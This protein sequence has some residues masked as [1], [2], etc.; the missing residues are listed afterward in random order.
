M[1]SAGTVANSNTAANATSTA[2]GG[3][4]TS[5]S[6]LRTQLEAPYDLDILDQANLPL[7]G[8]YEYTNDGT[9]VNIY[10]FDSVSHK[11]A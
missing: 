9:G 10:M 1:P 8:K 3:V 2:A 11:Q 7:D 5:V 4:V 6:T